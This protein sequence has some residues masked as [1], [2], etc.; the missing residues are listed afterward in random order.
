MR[1]YLM[2]GGHIVNVELLP[3]L[4]DQEAIEKSHILFSNM[5]EERYDGF[6]LWEGAR[7]ILRHERQEPPAK[8][9]PRDR[10]SPP[11]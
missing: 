5:P 10:G 2:K 6:E 3:G 9:P 1:C 8:T 4:S 7:F 11:G